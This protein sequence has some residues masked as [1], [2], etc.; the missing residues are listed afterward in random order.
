M[1]TLCSMFSKWTASHGPVNVKLHSGEYARRLAESRVERMSCLPTGNLFLQQQ[2][3]SSELQYWIRT[4][5][6]RQINGRNMCLCQCQLW[7]DTEPNHEA[8]ILCSHCALIT[9]KQFCILNSP[10]QKTVQTWC[11]IAWLCVCKA[12]NNRCNYK[13]S[14]YRKQEVG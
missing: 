13:Q 7:M 5:H 4:K 1:V 10:P 9:L 14:Y 12:V 11:W 3:T 6:F 8:S 2:L